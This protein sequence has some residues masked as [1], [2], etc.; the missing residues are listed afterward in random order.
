[1]DLHH[2]RSSLKFEIHRSILSLLPW[3]QLIALVD[4]QSIFVLESPSFFNDQSE[5]P[6]V[7]ATPRHFGF[8]LFPVSKLWDTTNYEYKLSG[9]GLFMARE[10]DLLHTG[11]D[12]KNFNFSLF[13]AFR[14]TLYMTAW[15]HRRGNNPILWL[16]LVKQFRWR[17]GLLLSQIEILR[18]S[19]WVCR[20]VPSF[21]LLRLIHRGFR[22]PILPQLRKI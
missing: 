13:W 10:M 12:I 8:E 1:M 18:F 4:E 7:T 11:C 20:I 17:V 14:M 21:L 6:M 5:V 3:I 9:F 19:I 2:P 16:F 15:R 22:Y